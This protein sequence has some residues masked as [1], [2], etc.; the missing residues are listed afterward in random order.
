MKRSF[1]RLA[2][3]FTAVLGLMGLGSVGTASAA[4]TAVATTQY[5]SGFGTGSSVWTA[6][7]SAYNDAY[8]KASF[9]G[10]ARYTCRQS[11]IPYTR[12]ISPYM[13]WSNVTVSC[14]KWT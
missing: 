2:L 12:Q 7:S 3:A 9:A 10:Y 6:E 5:F 11:G 13:Y 4:G 8:T 1:L 14:T